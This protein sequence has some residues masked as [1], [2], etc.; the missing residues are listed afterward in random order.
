MIKSFP[1]SKVK[2]IFH[3]SRN[4]FFNLFG[5]HIFCQTYMVCDSIMHLQQ[6]GVF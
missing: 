1:F 6:C 3:G 5:N 2:A 4:H